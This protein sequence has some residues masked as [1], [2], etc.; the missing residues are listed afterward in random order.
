ML[1]EDRVQAWLDNE[2][3]KAF[4]L[5]VERDIRSLQQELDDAEELPSIYRL[6]GMRRALK[7]VLDMPKDGIPPLTDEE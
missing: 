3:T 6:Q 1:W 2:V 4:F 7:G 5:D